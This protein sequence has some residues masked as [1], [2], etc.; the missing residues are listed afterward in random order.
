M[1]AVIKQ[2]DIAT[3]EDYKHIRLE[4]LRNEPQAFSGNY[5]EESIQDNEFHWLRLQVGQV[6]GAYVDNR[7]CG[8]TGVVLYVGKKL[9]HNA[10]LWGV[11]VSPD[12]RGKGI[13][14]KLVGQAISALPAHVKRLTLGVEENNAGALALYKSFGF[15]EYGFDRHA[16]RHNGTYYNERMMVK[17]L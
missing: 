2:F 8:M 14:R 5:D 11:Y 9:E 1:D 6:Y 15:E 12:Q 4:A 7:I 13:A 17:F 3:L 10:A 16:F